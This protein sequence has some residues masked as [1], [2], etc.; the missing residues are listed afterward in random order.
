MQL[1]IAFSFALRRTPAWRVC[2]LPI[3]AAAAHAAG[4]CCVT[5][6]QPL[7]RPRLAHSEASERE[8]REGERERDVRGLCEGRGCWPVTHA[9]RLSSLFAVTHHPNPRPTPA[10]LSHITEKSAVCCDMCTSLKNERCELL[11][12][13]VLDTSRS[14]GVVSS[15]MGDVYTCHNTPPP[16]L[17]RDPQSFFLPFLLPDFCWF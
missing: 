8:R 11:F 16:H 17:P 14:K 3:P 13:S 6:L 1:H 9:G 4:D 15:P 10:T 2:S 7:L 12:G 5:P